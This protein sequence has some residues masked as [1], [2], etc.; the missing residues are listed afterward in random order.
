M[1][2]L[3]FQNEKDAE[4]RPNRLARIAGPR[5]RMTGVGLPHLKALSHLKRLALCDTHITDAGLEHLTKVTSREELNLCGTEVTDRPGHGEL[6]VIRIGGQHGYEW[7]AASKNLQRRVA[8]DFDVDPVKVAG[9]DPMK[10]TAIKPIG[11]YYEYRDYGFVQ[12]LQETIRDV[13]QDQAT[14]DA[15]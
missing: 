10:F 13:G 1:T 14:P 9:Q 5:L 11:P 7:P 12:S 8:I 15:E 4:I 2:N 3:D 6:S